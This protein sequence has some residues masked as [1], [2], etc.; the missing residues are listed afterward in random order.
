MTVD[1]KFAIRSIGQHLGK[2]KTAVDTIKNFVQENAG[3]LDEAGQKIADNIDKELNKVLNK[4]DAKWSVFEDD[5]EQNEETTFN[6]LDKKIMEAKREAAEATTDL[7]K[8]MAK[9][10]PVLQADQHAAVA[11]VAGP[12][13]RIAVDQNYKPQP[14]PASASLGEFIMWERS[15]LAYMASN[16]DYLAAQQDNMK[17]YFLSIVWIRR[18]SKSWTTTP[19]WLR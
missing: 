8:L 15:F 14:L 3:S 4:L 10:A 2:V 12:P 17:R 9:K 11:A 7:Y 1:P 13:R 6:E 19:P 16:G 5:L 18:L